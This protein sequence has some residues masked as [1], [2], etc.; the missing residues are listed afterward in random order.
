M[1]L[2]T[3][4]FFFGNTIAFAIIMF[5]ANIAIR[6]SDGGTL[7]A[8][9]LLFNASVCIVGGLLY[10]ATVYRLTKKKIKR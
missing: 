7:N 10:S 9:S 4:E 3:R 1:K 8:R 2:D 6:F 5:F